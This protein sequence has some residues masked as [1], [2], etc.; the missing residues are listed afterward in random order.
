MRLYGFQCDQCG[1]RSKDK[2]GRWIEVVSMS[3]H[4][5]GDWSAGAHLRSDGLHYCSKD[6][7]RQHMET[8]KER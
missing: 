8:W 1:I 3:V 4:A 5:D 6:C 2:P 7:L